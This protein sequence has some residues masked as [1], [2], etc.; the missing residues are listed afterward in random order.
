LGLVWKWDCLL[1][2]D[3]INGRLSYS[4]ADTIVA[5]QIAPAAHRMQAGR[6]EERPHGGALVVAVFDQQASARAQAC[7]R[8]F[9]DDPDRVQ[10]I[11]TAGERIG[12]LEPEVTALQVR[13]LPGDIRRV[14]HDPIEAPMIRRGSGWRR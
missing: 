7:W 11:R 4:S 1:A 8:A 14:G 9:D 12:W 6:F 13:V 2:S 3:A 5:S 10:A